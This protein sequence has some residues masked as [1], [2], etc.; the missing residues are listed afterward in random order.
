MEC[1]ICALDQ[2]PR[3]LGEGLLKMGV[4]LRDVASFTEWWASV[5]G[6]AKTT[7]SAWERHRS[8]GHFQVEE[9]P[10]VTMD[11][12][13][14]S[15]DLDEFVDEMWRTWQLH[16]KNKVPDEHRLMKWLELRAKIRNDVSRRNEEKRMMAAL[17]EAQEE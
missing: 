5:H 14:V 13:P 15:L 4:A 2:K 9:K 10:Q 12:Q 1:S 16:N 6:T 3:K 7:K 17:E 8:Q 11:G